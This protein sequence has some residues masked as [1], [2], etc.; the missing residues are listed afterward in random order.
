MTPADLSWHGDGYP[1]L[2]DGPPWVMEEMI[3]AQ[4]GLAEPIAAAPGAGAIADAVIAG[5]ERRGADRRHGLRHVR[6]RRD[7]GR[8]AA[9]RGTAHAGLARGAGAAAGARCRSRSAYRRLCIGISHEGTTRATIARARGGARPPGRRPRALASR[10]TR[11]S[12]SSRITSLTTPLVDR[13]WCHTVAYASTILAGAAIAREIAGGAARPARAIA[14][15][16]R[17]G[18]RSTQL[19]A[20]AST[21][22]SRILTVGLGADLVTARE[23]ALKIEEGARIPSTALH[24]E[25]LLHGH[26]AGCD[27]G[28]TATRPLRRRFAWRRAARLAPGGAAG[29]ARAIGIPTSRSARRAALSGLPGRRRRLRAAR[30]RRRRSPMPCSRAQSRSSCSRSSSRTSWAATPISSAASSRPTARPRRW[31]RTAH[32]LVQGYARAH[33][34]TGGRIDV[35]R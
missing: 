13:S 14:R 29:A 19:A 30:A 20:Q 28:P 9:R 18:R 27:A 31:R 5:R 12:R 8:R 17:C 35:A 23:L 3:E 7:G 32:R 16:W 21:G 24:L 10:A 6:A 26:L 11:R 22:A 34:P 25:S 4:T 33:G 1:E 2:R 15:R